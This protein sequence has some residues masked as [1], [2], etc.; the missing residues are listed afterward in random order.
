MLEC[1]V[2]VSEGRDDAVL[3]E[4]ART[5]GD[6]LL[7]VHR[8]PDHHRAVFT[9][10][11]TEAP[12]RLAA[13]A[14]ESIDLRVH[15][16]VHPRFGVVDVVPFVPLEGATMADAVAARDAF[17]A[18]LGTTYD[19]PCFRYGP[20]RSLPEVRRGAFSTL[21]PDAGPA[22]AHPTAGACAVGARGV[23]IAYNV[24]VS[25]PDLAAVRTVAAA[26]RTPAVR[27]LG[28]AVGRRYQVS[29]NLVE[30]LVSGPD[31]VTEAVRSH[32]A[33]LGVEVTG[34]EL[35]G[36]LPRQ[37]FE[38]IDPADRERLDVAADRT[39]EGRLASRRPP[40]R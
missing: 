7:D 27:T 2:N 6:D 38:A 23:L 4:L 15:T 19:V 29:C 30:P 14:I 1:V 26:V 16:G 37:V 21:G 35:V 9:V 24:W 25:A 39:I 32:G 8:D 34:C 20:E 3:D 12:R 11:G 31:A 28:L 40:K 22:R 13:R 5:C 18:W 17:A 10:V 36:L 33:P